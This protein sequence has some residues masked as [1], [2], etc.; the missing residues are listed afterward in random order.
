MKR[1]CL[2]PVC[3]SAYYRPFHSTEACSCYQH[4]IIGVVDQGDIGALVLLDLSAAFDTVDHSILID[5]LIRRFGIDGS[6]KLGG[7]VLQQPE[8]GGIRWRH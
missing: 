6:S 3:Q 5:V 1:H 7:G 4:D 8:T 2:L